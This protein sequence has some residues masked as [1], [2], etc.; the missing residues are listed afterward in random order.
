MVVA[1]I[2]AIPLSIGPDGQ[3]LPSLRKLEEPTPQSITGY[4]DAYCG[5]VTGDI[6]VCQVRKADEDGYSTSLFEDDT[7]VGSWG[8]AW[9]VYRG[10]FDVRLGDLDS[11]GMDELVVVDHLSTSNGSAMTRDRVT[12]VSRYLAPDRS[13]LSFVVAEYCRECGEGTFV[14]RPG[15]S[16]AWIFATEWASSEVLDPRRGYGNYVVGRWFRYLPGKLV[17]EPGV[18]VRR[19]LNSLDRERFENR[20]GSPYSWFANGKGRSVTVDPAMGDGHVIRSITGTIDSGPGDDPDRAGY[21]VRFDD[22]RHIE[23]LFYVP[24][25]S[26]FATGGGGAPDTGASKERIDH[27][28]FITT[29]RILPEGVPPTALMGSVV[30]RR[31]KVDTYRDGTREQRVLWIQ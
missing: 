27:V 31:V 21:V 10:M 15:Q 30:G 14:R 26:L 28:G 7:M 13:W 5:K 3:T 6:R 11:D 1:A 19:Y 8:T 18:L 17:Q 29:G 16:G 12:I 23:F 9:G 2:L 24:V 22:G 20:E 25:Q 4:A